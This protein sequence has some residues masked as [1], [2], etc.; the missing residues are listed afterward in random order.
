MIANIQFFVLGLGG[1]EVF[2]LLVV[3]AVG[4]GSSRI[5][6][7]ARGLREAWKRF[8]Q[9]GFDVGRNLGGIHGKPA[10][11]ALSTDNKT[12]ELYDPALWRDRD[13]TKPD[14]NNRRL[15]LSRKQKIALII[16]ATTLLICALCKIL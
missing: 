2:F 4:F 12:V 10:A 5:P 6:P 11:E 9:S 7:F 14:S 1:G 8:D 16:A 13:L 3:A 15:K